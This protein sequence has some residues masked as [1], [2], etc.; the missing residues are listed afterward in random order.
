M[1]RFRAVPCT[2]S[3]TGPSLARPDWVSSA[4]RSIRFM[5]DPLTL[6]PLPTLPG[7][8]VILREPRDS[9]VDDRLRHP[10]DPEEADNY[11]SSCRR[12]WA[13]RRYHIREHLTATRCPPDPG[14]YTWGVEYDG[15]SQHRQRRASRGPRSA[16]C[17]L[18]KLYRDGWK[19]FI[20]MALLRSEH[21]T[22]AGI[23]RRSDSAHSPPPA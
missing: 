18:H 16:L 6:P 21:V 5:L 9:D 13:A 22:Q 19:D 3:C 10:I 20:M 2:D 7:D 11:G 14:T 1:A 15:Q 4:V 17:D 8:R 23:V 12:E